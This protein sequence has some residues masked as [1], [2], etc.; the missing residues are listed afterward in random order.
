MSTINAT[1]DFDD[2]EDNNHA[3]M[4]MPTMGIPRPMES[5]MIRSLRFCQRDET[6]ESV[7]YRVRASC[8]RWSY[9]SRSE[10]NTRGHS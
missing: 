2:K 9:L 3:R 6:S 5:S 8:S 10:I 1:D 4:H 7:I